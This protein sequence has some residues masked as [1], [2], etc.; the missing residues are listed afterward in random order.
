MQI[1]DPAHT[2]VSLR[3]GARVRNHVD[4]ELPGEFDFRF[5]GSVVNGTDIKSHSDIDLLCITNAF[6]Y[7]ADGRTPVSPWKGNA[8]KHLK[9]K[10]TASATRLDSSFPKAKVTQG[11][12]S[13]AVEGG[14]LARKVDV[15]AAAWKDTDRYLET[16]AKDYR[17]I[18]IL[19][20]SGSGYEGWGDLLQNQ[21]FLHNK[22]I[23]EKDERTSGGMRRSARLLKS[24]KYDNKIEVSSYD[25]VA[26]AYSMD[27]KQLSA[28]SIDELGL[29]TSCSDFCRYLLDS[30]KYRNALL[31]PDESRT[32]FK[33]YGKT[34]VEALQSLSQQLT[35]LKN[36][37]DNEVTSGMRKLVLEK[38][39]SVR[40][41]GNVYPDYSILEQRHF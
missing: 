16:H 24:I 28:S 10:R 18:K 14:S 13:V 1:M 17:A 7:V 40:T 37:I 21:P 32:I 5:Q 34:S 30:P 3:E 27:E 39:A 26:I 25:A 4:K 23:A 33:P 19:D 41:V 8:A 38:M 9:E 22:R 11:S 15:V 36:Q 12:K 6:Y 2:E 29:V 31:V 35:H 20:S